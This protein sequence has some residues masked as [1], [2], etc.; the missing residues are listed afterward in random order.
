MYNCFGRK[1][2]RQN[3]NYRVVFWRLVREIKL[4]II[5]KS[6]GP[7]RTS[8]MF[9]WIICQDKAHGGGKT[10]GFIKN[11]LHVC[12]VVILWKITF[13][14]YAPYTYSPRAFI[15]AVN[16]TVFLFFIVFWF[17]KSPRPM[18]FHQSAILC[19]SVIISWLE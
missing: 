1:N 12:G 3:N 11:S 13:Y 7:T 6:S 2:K 10:I 9:S 19:V 18:V 14:F 15:L 17:R 4:V 5:F 8:F 16:L